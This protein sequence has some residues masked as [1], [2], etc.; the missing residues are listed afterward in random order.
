[1]TARAHESDDRSTEFSQFALQ[2]HAPS[3]QYFSTGLGGHI[4]ML[5]SGALSVFFLSASC[6]PFPCLAF[7]CTRGQRVF[8]REWRCPAASSCSMNAM[9]S[10][11][12]CNAS[13]PTSELKQRQGSLC[14][15]AE[16]KGQHCSCPDCLPMMSI[17]KSTLIYPDCKL[18][19]PS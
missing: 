8:R 2:V 13:Y 17:S 11:L 18:E 6:L 10:R 14:A 1:M 4:S 3:R 5:D 15:R 7:L 12:L 19:T 9:H 16:K